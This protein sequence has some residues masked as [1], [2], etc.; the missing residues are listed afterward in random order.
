MKKNL[1]LLIVILTSIFFINIEKVNAEEYQIG[2]L[3]EIINPSGGKSFQ[4][5]VTDILNSEDFKG[6]EL[7]TKEPTEKDKTNEEV[8]ENHSDE[9]FGYLIDIYDE[10]TI[11]EF[12]LEPYMISLGSCIDD[13]ESL[14]NDYQENRYIKCPQLKDKFDNAFFDSI[15]YTDGDDILYWLEKSDKPDY[16]YVLRGIKKPKSDMEEVAKTKKMNY[17]TTVY[18]GE[19]KYSL[20][21]K[22]SIPKEETNQ[23]NIKNP[24]TSDKDVLLMTIASLLIIFTIVISLRKLKEN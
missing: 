13:Y 22:V 15:S 12:D 10:T 14:Y 23:E 2:D 4:F 7:V 19:T 5:Y 20:L 9:L 8:V 16:D 24:N 1:L 18:V 11:E 3:V 17:Y 6:V 21:K